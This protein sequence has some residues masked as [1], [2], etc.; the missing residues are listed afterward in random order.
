M[1]RIYLYSAKSKEKLSN[2]L[3]LVGCY[4]MINYPKLIPKFLK[5]IS[6]LSL[7]QF[8]FVIP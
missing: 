5:N 2:G 8:R 6:S 3:V 4:L 7:A 1:K